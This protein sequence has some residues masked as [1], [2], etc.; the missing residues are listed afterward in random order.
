M[1][2]T[3]QRRDIQDPDVIKQ[4]AL[5]VNSVNRLNYLLCLTVADIC[6][7]NNTLWNSW[8]QSLIREL[9]LSTEHQLK[10][11]MHNTPDLRERIRHHR[12]QALLLLRQTDIDEHKLQK[13][14]SRC[15]ADYFLRHTPSQL[16]W[17]ARH[18]LKHDLTAP[19]VLISTKSK[20]GG[21]EIFIWCP[22]V[23]V[24]RSSR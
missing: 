5:E 17:H 1:S 16:A 6:A 7:T 4:F 21:T 20:H 10:Q 3:A 22:T 15:H 14:W 9:Y 2:V 11:G 19:M 8:K 18:L 23:P 13:F 12:N 24:C